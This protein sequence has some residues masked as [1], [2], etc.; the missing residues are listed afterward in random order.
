MWVELTVD[1]PPNG[2]YN[3]TNDNRR[4]DASLV[5]SRILMGGGIIFFANV[6]Q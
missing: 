3:K 6:D 4:R 1:G 2:K 5:L